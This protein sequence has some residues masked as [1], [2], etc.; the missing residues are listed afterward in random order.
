MSCV[1]E[2][3]IGA[4]SSPCEFITRV[5][6]A[7][8][9]IGSSAAVQ[10][11]VEGMLQQRDTLET[12]VLASAASFLFLC[13]VFWPLEAAF[14]AKAGQRFFRPAWGTDLCFFLG[15][16]LLWS[17]LVL[18]ILAGFSGWRQCYEKE[19][20]LDRSLAFY[21]LAWPRLTHICSVVSS[22]V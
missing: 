20:L 18:W 1:I 21:W 3:E 14:P 10:L 16:Y 7:P 9:G 12:I 5:V 19:S 2:L 17:G 4:G 13:L 11:D 8:S 22:A 15:Q 6:N